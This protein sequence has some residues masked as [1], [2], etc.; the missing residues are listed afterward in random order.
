MIELFKTSITNLK[1]AK[2]I[3]REN[4]SKFVQDNAN[5]ILELDSEKIK[6]FDSDK[7]YHSLYILE[8]YELCIFY[9]HCVAVRVHKG[10][11]FTSLGIK[12]KLE[13]YPLL[14]V[15]LLERIIIENT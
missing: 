10:T 3:L 7:I 6:A 4:F 8:S 11:G 12:N 1:I 9:G 15:K 13:N 5:E 2:E 14:L